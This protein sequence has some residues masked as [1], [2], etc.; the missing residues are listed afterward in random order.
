MKII[1]IVRTRDNAEIIERFIMSYQW[2][3]KILV[4]DN[5]SQDDTVSICKRLP[6]TQVRHFLE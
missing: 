5:E 6:K 2:A 1:V 4:A 3:D